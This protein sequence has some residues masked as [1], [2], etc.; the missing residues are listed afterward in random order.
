M[1]EN[2][3]CSPGLS[4]EKAEGPPRAISPG[5]G[6]VVPAPPVHRRPGWT[7]YR[8]IGKEALTPTLFALVGLTSVVLT[9]NLLGLSD[10]FV[11][12]G[13]SGGSVSLIAFYQAVPTATLMLPF[14]VLLGCLVALGRMGA[15]LEIL[16]LEASGV[17][18]ARLVWPF[19]AYAAVMMLFSAGLSLSVA[20]WASRSLDR[21]FVQISIEKPWSQIQQGIVTQFGDIRLEAREVNARGDRLKGI[22]LWLPD[23]GQTIF[24]SQGRIDTGEDG[25]TEISLQA[26]RVVL[27][28]KDGPKTL[29]FDELTTR[30]PESSEILRS[31]DDKLSGLS[32]AELSQRARDFVPKNKRQLSRPVIEYQRRFSMPFA[33]LIF[34]ILAVPIFLLRSNFSRAA[35]GVMGLLCTIAYYGLIQLGEGL[36]QSGKIGVVEAVWLPN[37]ILTVLAGVLIV[38]ARREGVL[39]HSFDRPQHK[40]RRRADPKLSERSPR[41]Y[42]LPRYIAGRFIHLALLSFMIL[43]VAYLLID[44]MERLAWFSQYRATGLEI[45]RFYGARVVLL[46][47]RV[48]PMSLL[49]ATALTVSLLAVEG[50]LIGMRACGIPAPRALLPV[51]I[52]SAFVVPADAILNNVL[53]PRTNAIADELKRSEIKG[54]YARQLDERRKNAVWYRMGSKVLE[55]ERF[56]PD[57]GSAWDLSI[58]ELGED[59]LPVERIDATSARHIGNGWWLLRDASRIE[60]SEG[61]V[62][63]V[64][65]PN[66]VN[67][68]EAL[69]AEL[70]TM[71]LSVGDLLGLIEEAEEDNVDPRPLKVD[72]HVKLAQPLACIVLPALLL[73]F[74]VGGPP[75]PGPAQTLLL[76]AVVGIGYILLTGVS[77][78]L[79]YG[80]AMPPLIGGWG[81]ILVF[82]SITGFFG[83]RLWRRL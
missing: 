36:A 70:D 21:V 11:N 30:L 35:G 31:V 18:A 81:P 79:G 20:P 22:L 39:G 32:L 26:G 25:S 45:V 54:S 3:N 50:E 1:G 14:A 62:R 75:F 80:G 28:A 63:T 78:S 16:A 51:L 82:M 17:T 27:S 23:V 10:L 44:I 53:V 40:S 6:R 74:A 69:P 48:I 29:T 19:V 67:L 77:R 68:G 60:V 55:A 61:K 8:L 9:Q 37:L 64:P 56:D 66:F 52:I 33:T 38:R 2:P 15:D 34:G 7:L 83:A 71:H 57:R 12:R 5:E 73:F 59:R 49:V 4:A 43:V 76:S 47:S 42:P 24:A 72:Y 58:Y 13:L 65:P 46:A 41:R